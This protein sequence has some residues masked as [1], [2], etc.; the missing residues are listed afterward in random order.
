LALLF[1][2][3]PAWSGVLEEVAE[4][5]A[6]PGHLRLFQYR[7]DSLKTPAPLVVALHGCQQ[8]AA[9]Y[10]KQAGWIEEAD[11]WGFL[12]LLPEQRLSNNLQRCF[13]W[14]QPSSRDQGEAGSIRQ[15]IVHAQQNT[16]IDAQRLYAAGLSAGGA[17][18]A[19]LLTNDPDLFAGGAIIAGVPYGCASGIVSGL[20][21]QLSGR[22]LEPS[23]WGD[24]VRQASAGGATPK[25]WPI[26][27]IWQGTADW[28]VDAINA[29]ELVEQWTAVHGLARSAA[30][31]ETGQNYS[32]QVY[33]DAAGQPRV[34][35]YLI[36]GMGHG[37]AIDPGPGATQCG[38][39]ADYAI[40]V[41]ICASYQILR[42]WGL[43]S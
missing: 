42:F 3:T 43:G 25:K 27:S 2:T 26:V 34:E 17:M 30:T 15:M 36:T 40:P 28:V 38:I 5:G 21:C 32:H 20:R 35:S 8:T 19:V 24:L 33:R 10:A 23:A 18:T 39:E 16:A 12:L 14:F 9:D 4:F 31:T 7:P 11:R 1:I 37:Q 6:N 22:D 13:N 41:G 29:R